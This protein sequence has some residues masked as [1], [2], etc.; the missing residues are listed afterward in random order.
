MTVKSPPEQVII[1]AS[2]DADVL[3]VLV[4]NL[5]EVLFVRDPSAG[6]MLFVNPVFEELWG[7]SRQQ[8]YDQPRSFLDAVVPEDRPKVLEALRRQDQNEI[9][10]ELEYRIRN[11][12]G[13]IRYIYARSF[14]VHR[15]AKLHRVVGLAWDLS[16]RR[17]AEEDLLCLQ[18]SLEEQIASRTA[19]LERSLAEKDLLLDELNHRVKNNLQIVSSLL[20]LQ[21][22]Q[23]VDPAARAVLEQSRARIHTISLAHQHLYSSQNMNRV[24]L[25]VYAKTI[26]TD[27]A[28]SHCLAGVALSTRCEAKRLDLPIDRAVPFGLLLNELLTNAYRHAFPE[29]HGRLTVSLSQ[30]SFG[31]V[32]LEVAD[33]GIGFDAGKSEE[34]TTLGL[35]MVR[36]LVTQL[37]G[38]LAI[39][40][41]EGTTV[42]V[43]FP[44]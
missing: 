34:V 9:P 18:K 36:A 7:I 42:R 14:F 31:E 22:A 33:S 29:G 8:L 25:G 15:G 11:T 32:R 17:R 24:D 1:G 2:E 19:E 44:T 10:F 12:A 5:R 41:S 39:D 27:V 6:K 28:T 23:T 40:G 3:Q 38:E 35:R 43:R 30:P 21:A 20:R 16:A 26:A 13:E 37:N 4:N